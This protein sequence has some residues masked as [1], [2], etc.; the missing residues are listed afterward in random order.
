MNNSAKWQKIGL[1]IL[2]VVLALVL[3]VMIF[4][5]TYV[6][7]LLSLMGPPTDQTQGSLSLE[8]IVTATETIDPTYT[9][10]VVDPSDVTLNTLPPTQPPPQLDEEVINILLVG[11][12]RRSSEGRQ[13]SDT[14]ILCTFNTV[15]NTVTMT[16]F[17]RDTYVYIPGYGKN[18]LNAA[19]YFGGFSLI[20]ET[21]MV[22]FGVHVDANVEVDF[23][24][25]KDIVDLLGGVEIELTEGEADYINKKLKKNCVSPGV[26][27]LNGEEALWY[28]RNRSTSTLTGAKNDF[29]RTERQRRLISALIAA[30]KDKSV[31]TML[32]LVD[33]ILPMVTTNLTSHEILTYVVSL[34]PMLSKAEVE[35]LRIPTNSTYYD[36]TISGIGACLVPDLADIRE[37]LAEVFETD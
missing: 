20:N 15:K 26:Q 3:I 36:Q 10:P 27:I 28:A 19:Y 32:G 22:N 35:T 9:G 23:G 24:S 33:D 13:R 2:C 18:K 29:G 12:D 25:F 4:A 1:S 16:S 6:H 31:T 30:Y 17:M 14:M 37:I 7:Y 8:D 11:Q 34:F 5:T 21:L